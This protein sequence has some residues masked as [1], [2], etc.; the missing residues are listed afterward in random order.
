MKNKW[1]VEYLAEAAHDLETLDNSQRL[2][3]R[4]AIEKV[5]QNPL[6]FFDG[7]YGKPLGNKN[8][9]NLT[10]F[11]KIKLVAAGIRIVYKLVKQDDKMIIVV[12]GVR[13]DDEVYYIA[14]KRASDHGL[15]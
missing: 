14:K 2:I 7:G 13:E 12:I 5:K 11:L 15:T 9:L 4:K 10:G 3:V 8:G 1:V 6:P